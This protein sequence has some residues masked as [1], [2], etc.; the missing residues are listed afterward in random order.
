MAKKTN[1]V[2][3][4][5]QNNDNLNEEEETVEATP[6]VRVTSAVKQVKVRAIEDI[7]CIVACTPYKIAKDTEALIP[8]DVAAIL[9]FAHKAYRL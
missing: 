9:V 1:I 7:D 6:E 2:D 5:I 8:S 3:E 4:D